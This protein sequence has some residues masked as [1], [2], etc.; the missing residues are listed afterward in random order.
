[1]LFCRDRASPNLATT[2]LHSM[3]F[4]LLAMSSLLKLAGNVGGWQSSTG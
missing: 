4:D 2:T 3:I 1:M